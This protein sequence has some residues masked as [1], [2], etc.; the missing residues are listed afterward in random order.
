MNDNVLNAITVLMNQLKSAA[1]DAVKSSVGEQGVN[2]ADYIKTDD[3]DIDNLV[4]KDDIDPDSVLTNYDFDPYDCVMKDE[5]DV[6][7]VVTQ[8]DLKDAVRDAVDKQDWSEKFES[9]MD[10]YDMSEYIKY[11][12]VQNLIDE[13]L[14]VMKVGAE[15]NAELANEMIKRIAKV[16]YKAAMDPVESLPKIVKIN[17]SQDASFHPQSQ[18]VSSIT[19]I[20]EGVTETDETDL[21]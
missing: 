1:D 19:D 6:D 17:S 5:L 9:C 18:A 3:I 4:T 21:V 7:D 11:D 13:R 12:E 2:L 8:S 14:E 10:D 15:F 20:V 16:L